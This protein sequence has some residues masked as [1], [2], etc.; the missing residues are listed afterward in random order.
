MVA[1]SAA[2]LTALRNFMIASVLGHLIWEAAQ[3][4]LYTIWAE[5]TAWQIAFAAVHCTGGDVL[6]AALSVLAALLMFG[7]GWPSDRAAFR[8]VMA[9]AI[10]LGVGYA[11]FS[12]WLNVN[13]RGSWVYSAWMPQLPPLGTGLSPVLQ[14]VAVP[15]LAFKWTSRRLVRSGEVD[16]A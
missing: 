5:G 13:V 16:A 11:V 15:I 8:N 6:I 3:L 2:R 7:R 10:V 4:P 1:E 14:W 12:E 9:A